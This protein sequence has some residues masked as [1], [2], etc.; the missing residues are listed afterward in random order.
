METRTLTYY[1]VLMYRPGRRRR[2]PLSDPSSLSL[3]SSLLLVPLQGEA[4]A[5]GDGVQAPPTSLSSFEESGSWPRP[6]ARARAR[7]R[8]RAVCPRSPSA[9]PSCARAWPPAPRA[10][11][12]CRTP[13]ASSSRRGSPRSTAAASSRRNLAAQGRVLGGDFPQLTGEH[14]ERLQRQKRGGGQ[15]L[16][17]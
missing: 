1:S 8:V 14:V 11:R 4:G 12:P 5:R 9:S 2:E 16:R 13:A 17:L 6:R 3:S 10:G 7:A 15:R